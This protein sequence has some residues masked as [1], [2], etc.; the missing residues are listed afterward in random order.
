MSG[1]RFSLTGIT[2]LLTGGAGFLGSHLAERL[3]SSGCAVICLDNLSTGSKANIEHLCPRY[4]TFIEGDVR[5]PL[6]VEADIIFNL[7]CPASPEK[8]ST[9]PIGTV[10]TCVLGAVNVLDLATKLKIPI[11]HTSTSEVYG[12]PHV[13]PQPETYW[14]NVNPTGPRACYDEGKRCAETLFFDYHRQSG[15]DI[16]VARIFNTYGPRMMV[17]DGRVVSNFIVSALRG[18][19]LKI[20][21]NPRIT[22]SFCFV[23]DMIEGLMKLSQSEISGP[24]NLGRSEE[25]TLHELAEIIT[26]LT[27]SNSKITVTNGKEDD[28][29]R[30]LPDTTQALSTLGWQA[31][32]NLEQG[33]KQTI[34]YF[35]Q[36]LS[37]PRTGIRHHTQ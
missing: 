11:V 12:D 9:D 1:N 32:T 25:V 13:S 34:E 19:P 26:A 29:Q 2:A 18:D 7:A 30:R 8:Y 4:F 5:R 24:I 17:D 37:K 20:Y 6:S 14:G 3:I 15:T 27:G 36:L 22:R 33:L 10:T 23:S 31:T 21:G 16:K 35:E 28:P